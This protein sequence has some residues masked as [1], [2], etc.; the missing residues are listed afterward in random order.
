MKKYCEECGKEVEAKIVVK[1]EKYEVYGENIEVK[2]QV[3]TC[4]HCGEEFFCEELDNAT[5]IS[6][7]NEYRK[8]H[9]LLLPDEIKK[10]R[11]QYGL[12]QRSFAKLLNWGDKTIRRY[13]N[14]SIQDKA[15][16]SLLLFLRE[17]ENM[18]TYLVENEILLDDKQKSKLLDKIEELQ[19][20]SKRKQSE[21]LVKV[22]FEKEPSIE[23]GFRSLD[24]DKLCAMVIFFAQK[25][26]GLLK[27]KLLKLLNYS[28]MLFYKENGI[29]ISGAVYV[30]LPYGPVLQNYDI[31]FGMMEADK[32]M[33]IEVEF[34]NGYEKHQVIPDCNMP[35]GVLTDSEI[36]VLERIYKRF[37]DFG[38]VEISN[39]SHKEKGYRET[40][41][42]E[43]IS[44][45]YAKDIE[46]F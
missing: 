9:M 4:E 15:H 13:E 33:H 2:T 5:L 31:L 38:S 6:V 19:Q 46:I 45:A 25:C 42:G 18:K 20:D 11:E 39:F 23:N 14:G 8:R 27:V 44:Y 28:D 36:E 43:V 35:D 22:F 40:K 7:Y 30:H 29:S 10:I 3:L 17:P 1:K 37:A 12:S 32:I 16:N 34:D 21:K 41:K 24:F 26:N